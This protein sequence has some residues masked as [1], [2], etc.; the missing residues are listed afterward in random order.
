[1]DEKLKLILDELYFKVKQMRNCCTELG[2]DIGKGYSLAIYDF[3]E[4]IKII[5]NRFENYKLDLKLASMEDVVF[6]LKVISNFLSNYKP[7]V[8]VNIPYSVRHYIRILNNNKCSN[9]RSDKDLEIDHKL[10]ISR[11]GTDDIDNL[12]LLCKE[13][14]LKKSNLIFKNGTNN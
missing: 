8:R 4:M 1:M 3:E 7:P 9:C 13:C 14:N 12:T 2:G 11:G 10:P 5:E 6:E